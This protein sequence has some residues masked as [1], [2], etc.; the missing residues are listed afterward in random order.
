MPPYSRPDTRAYCFVGVDEAGSRSSKQFTSRKAAIENSPGRQPWE[1]VRNCIRSPVG[2]T[3]TPTCSVLSPLRGSRFLVCCNLQRRPWVT[4]GRNAAQHH[5]FLPPI[6]IHAA[7]LRWF[8]RKGGLVQF[9]GTA[10]R[11]LAEPARRVLC[12]NW[13]CPFFHNT[14][15]QSCFSRMRKILR[16]VLVPPQGYPVR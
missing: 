1:P 10:R 6:I 3:E 8:G 11:E 12:I 15:L 4:L 5:T 7:A 14:P 16:K 13:T 2:A 9:A